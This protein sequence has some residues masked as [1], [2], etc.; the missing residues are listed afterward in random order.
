[1]NFINLVQET[2]NRVGIQGVGPS[3]IDTTTYEAQ[4]V[5]AVKDSWLNIQNLRP[6]WKWMRDTKSFLISQGVSEYTPL[7]IFGPNHRHRTWLKDTFYITSNGNK[8]SLRYVDYDVYINRYINNIVEGPFY[9]FTI[10]PYDNA[11]LFP[12]PDEAY[13]IDCDYQKSPQELTTD[14]AVPELPGYFH[15]AIV[16]GAVQLY[17]AA[18]GFL[19]VYDEFSTQHAIVLGNLMREQNPRERLKVRGIA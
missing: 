3:S 2:R 17:A 8:S 7:T 5:S 14:S 4:V 11:L 10:R 1:M 9:E 15:M 18:I 13:S 16:Y 12:L 19:E 6:V